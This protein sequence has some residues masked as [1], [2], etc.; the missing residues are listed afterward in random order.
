MRRA[1]LVVDMT[2]DYFPKNYDVS[3]ENSSGEEL[4]PRIRVLEEAFLQARLPVIYSSDRHLRTD[5]EL[6]KWGPHSMKGKDGSK[7]VEG[8]MT[9]GVRVLERNWTSSDVRRIKRSE[10]L[11]D[12]EKGAYSGF[13]DNGGEPT[14]LHALLKR[15]GFGPG[16]RICISGVHTNCCVKHSA[17]DAWFRGYVPVVVEDCV[18]AFKDITGK[19]SMGHRDAL[20]YMRYWYEA[21]I[22]PSADLMAE[23]RKE[24][25]S[26]A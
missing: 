21:E 10:L 2:N 25:T 14:A 15:L 9:K 4:I 22:K 1:L 16:D 18:D 7:I 13:T 24:S 26:S 11:F 20:E 8:L 19:G 3:L 12:V 6:E 23:I 17:A 5:F